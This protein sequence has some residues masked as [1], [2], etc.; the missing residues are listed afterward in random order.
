MKNSPSDK[1]KLERVNIQL[2]QAEMN[3]LDIE[4]PT[5]LDVLDELAII[6]STSNARKFDSSVG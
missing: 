5:L 2:L 3:V 6:L 1:L 4:D